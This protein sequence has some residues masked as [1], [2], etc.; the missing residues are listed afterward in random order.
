MKRNNDNNI[1]IESLAEVAVAI[2][3][4]LLLCLVVSSLT[5][6]SRK[7]YVPVESKTETRVTDTVTRFRTLVITDTVLQRIKE[8]DL[9]YD[10]VAPILDSLNNVI[11]WERWHFRERTKMADSERQRLMAVND[12]LRRVKADTVRIERAVPYE[13]PRKLTPWQGFR[14]NAFWWLIGAVAVAGAA[15]V[16]RCEVGR[17]HSFRPMVPPPDH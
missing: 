15:G 3:I 10:S 12:S 9:R 1:R 4:A 6:C 16:A 14:I 7:V 8:T 13:V 2:A 11:G 5:S 17:R